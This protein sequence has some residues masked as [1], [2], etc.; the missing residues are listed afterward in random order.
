[1]KNTKTYIALLFTILICVGCGSN[2][3][4][5]SL[6]NVAQIV[7]REN[8]ELEFNWAI[9]QS[10]SQI[11]LIDNANHLKFSG[12]SVYVSLPFFGERHIGGAYEKDGGINYTGI[13]TNLKVSEVTAKDY[14]QVNFETSRKSENF[15]YSLILY[16]G[17]NSRLQVNSNQRSSI[18][19]RGVYKESKKE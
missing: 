8:Y 4:L 2:R 16:P 7:E 3:D 9:P 10:G 15:I 18:S 19:F 5:G 11:N 17:G 6:D 1:M 12:D 14:V 13:L